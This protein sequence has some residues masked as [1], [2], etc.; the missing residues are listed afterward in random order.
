MTKLTMRVIMDAAFEHNVAGR[1]IDSLLSNFRIATEELYC[2][3][4][5]SL[6]RKLMRSFVP[7]HSIELMLARKLR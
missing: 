5:N 2:Q 3:Q 4:L 6:F 7:E 1:E